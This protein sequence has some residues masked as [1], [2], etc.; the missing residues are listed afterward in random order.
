MRTTLIIKDQTGS[1]KAHV[2]VPGSSELQVQGGAQ[3]ILPYSRV[4]VPQKG[5]V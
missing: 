5:R 2:G 3:A 1:I 4:V